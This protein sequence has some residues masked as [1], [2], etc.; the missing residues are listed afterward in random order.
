MEP[1]VFNACGSYDILCCCNSPN[2]MLLRIK[3]MF[4]ITMWWLELKQCLCFQI[5]TYFCLY[6]QALCVF[7]VSGDSTQTNMYVSNKRLLFSSRCC[8]LY[9]AMGTNEDV[10]YLCWHFGDFYLLGYDQ[11]RVTNGNQDETIYNYNFVVVAFYDDVQVS[12]TIVRHIWDS[13]RDISDS[14]LG[15]PGID[16]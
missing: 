1:N 8:L 11:N 10:Y 9:L 13:V 14:L 16:Q 4:N 2:N 7:I 3:E 15:Y 12:I 6:L 5:V